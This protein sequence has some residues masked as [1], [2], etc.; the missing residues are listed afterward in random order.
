MRF[1]PEAIAEPPD[2]VRKPVLAPVFEIFV[3]FAAVPLPKKL[4]AGTLG[5]MLETACTTADAVDDAVTVSVAFTVSVTVT[6]AAHPAE[7]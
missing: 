1:Q 6:A 4:P 5:E 7:L 3:E 2:N